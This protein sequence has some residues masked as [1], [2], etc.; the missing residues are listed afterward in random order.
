MVGCGD[1]V[2]V[3]FTVAALVTGWVGMP[4]GVGWDVEVGAGVWTAVAVGRG[5]GVASAPHANRAAIA[6]II[7]KAIT[8]HLPVRIP[9]RV[10]RTLKSV[11]QWLRL[12]AFP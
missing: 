6:R 11:V 2:G 12:G 10:L 8:G 5:V 3:C 1:A 9:S 4:V 7:V